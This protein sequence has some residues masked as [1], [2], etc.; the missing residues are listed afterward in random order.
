M[1]RPATLMLDR[2]RK[3]YLTYYN[4]GCGMSNIS[5]TP[6]E[7]GGPVGSGGQLQI[8]GRWCYGFQ[9]E[10]TSSGSYFSDIPSIA[11]VS[12]GGAASL[13]SPGTMPVARCTSPGSPTP[14]R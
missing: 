5:F 14:H 1:N 4:T 12:S 6:G 7:V 8:F 11:S 3:T 9:Q 2:R 10:I 13:N